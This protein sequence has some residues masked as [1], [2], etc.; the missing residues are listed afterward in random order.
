MQTADDDAFTFIAGAAFHHVAGELRWE[1]SNGR[2]FIL[3][4]VDGDGLADLHI[5]AP[6]P[7]IQA[8]D[9]IL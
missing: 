4:D 5:I 3:G 9:F 1:V 2:L 6:G 8:A 7:A